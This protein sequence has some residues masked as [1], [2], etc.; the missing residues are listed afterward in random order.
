MRVRRRASWGA[1]RAMKPMGPAAPV[2]VAARITPRTVRASWVRCT[3][4]PSAAAVSGS[5][6][7]GRRARFAHTRAGRE[8]RRIQAR[9]SACSQPRPLR[10]PVSHS[11]TC[12]AAPSSLSVR[13]S[14]TTAERATPMPTPVSTNRLGCMPCRQ[15]STY[16]SA[17]APRPPAT[18]T[19]GSAPGEATVPVA[20][21]RT[22]A[23]A[24][25]C[26]TPMT[27]GLASGLRVTVCT[28][29]PESPYAAPTSAP[30]T[31]RGTR[32]SPTI[33]SYEP[34]WPRRTRQTSPGDTYV[35]PTHAESTVTPARRSSSTTTTTAERRC[36][37]SEKERRRRTERPAEWG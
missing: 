25:P 22:V 21:A 32:S 4:T 34:P 36:R 20:R 13:Y 14:W 35:C 37:S 26:P 6:P 18:E 33:R 3:R 5:R 29:A 8:R 10:L 28:R 19:A 24:A 16:T 31:I 17:A 2:A 23:A 9:G 27:S 7:S 30:S 12:S 1:V 15:A 11:L